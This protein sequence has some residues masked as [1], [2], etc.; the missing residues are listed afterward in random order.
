MQ[1]SQ[2][3]QIS[4]PIVVQVNNRHMED[5]DLFDSL[6]GLNRTKMRWKIWHDQMWSARHYYSRGNLLEGQVL[7]K[8]EVFTTSR[9]SLQHRCAPQA[10]R[11]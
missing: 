2:H 1:R 8:V 10:K 4:C 9:Q 3:K 11:T 7:T 5:V 6:I